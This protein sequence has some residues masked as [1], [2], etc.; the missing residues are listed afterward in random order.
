MFW[1]SSAGLIAGGIAFTTAC[2]A[3]NVS[4][5]GLVLHLGSQV[6]E[7][8]RLCLAQVLLCN[9]KLHQFEALRQM[10]SACVFCLGLAAW[11]LEWERFCAQRA[12]QRLLAHPHWY[13]AAGVL[14]RNTSA[15]VV[16]ISLIYKWQC[17]EHTDGYVISFSQEWSDPV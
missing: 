14:L 2:G 12:W 1:S 9:M 8:I 17:G 16:D 15:I 13:L 7:A 3:R 5:L 11:L 4:R 6:V 10:S